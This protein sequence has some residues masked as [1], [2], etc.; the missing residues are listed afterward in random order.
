MEHHQPDF[1]RAQNGPHGAT[2]SRIDRIY[3]NIPAWRIL[4]LDVRT[5]TVGHVSD[6]QRLSDHVPV[7]SFICVA[8]QQGQ[9]SIPVWATRDPFYMKALDKEMGQCR[10]EAMSPAD[11][12]QRLKRCMRTACKHVATKSLR[13]GAITIEE[14]IYWS[15][16]C[17]RA[18]FHGIARRAAQAMIAYPKLEDFILANCATG[19]MLIPDRDG[20]DQHISSLMRES[21]EKL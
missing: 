18:L 16:V 19:T 17:A 8:K 11:G 5:S 21:I 9:G 13:R 14:K 3:S 1:T 12:V 20:L 7:L 6:K 10:Y 2:L 15:L 4:S